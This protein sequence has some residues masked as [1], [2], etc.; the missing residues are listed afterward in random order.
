MVA[1][2]LAHLKLGTHPTERHDGQPFRQSE[3]HRTA[4]SGQPLGFKAVVLWVKSDLVERSH[5][6]GFPGLGDGISPCPF[7]WAGPEDFTSH[8]GHSPL[9]TRWKAKERRHWEAACE[10]CEVAVPFDRENQVK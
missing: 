1:W 2:S 10:A 6:L 7:C 4:C 8:L 3:P 5:S 9:G